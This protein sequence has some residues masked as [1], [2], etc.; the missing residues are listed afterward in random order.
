MG[1]C[2]L[3][4]LQSLLPGPYGA[5]FSWGSLL[6]SQYTCKERKHPLVT[7]ER[8]RGN[9]Y[10]GRLG[11]T[12]WPQGVPSQPTGYELHLFSSLGKLFWEGLAGSD[13]VQEGTPKQGSFLIHTLPLPS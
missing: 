11:R 1:L 12:E 5:L 3:L 13:L 9:G 6:Y 4:F 2:S 8:Y 7:P 10:A